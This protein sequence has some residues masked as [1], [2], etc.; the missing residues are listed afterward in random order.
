[1]VADRVGVGGLWQVVGGEAERVRGR[2]AQQL[3]PATVMA[4]DPGGQPAA[5]GGGPVVVP[6]CVPPRGR[7]VTRPAVI[8]VT[9]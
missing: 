4:T 6:C 1:V 9:A 5:D 7:R 3:P 8:R 2:R